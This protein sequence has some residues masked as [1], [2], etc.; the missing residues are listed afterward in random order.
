MPDPPEQ[1]AATSQ[2]VKSV[3]RRRRPELS[4]AQREVE[5]LFAQPYIDPLTQYLADTRGDTGKTD[6]RQ[7]VRTERDHRCAVIAAR[8]DA[9]PPTEQSLAAYRTGYE[10]SCPED[11]AAYAQRLTAL[12]DQP[13]PEPAIGNTASP[14]L[15]KQLNDCY[16]LTAI[17]NFSEAMKACRQP[18]VQGDIKAQTNMALMTYALK[19]YASAYHWAVAAAPHSV[20]AAR[21]LGQMY[22]AGQGVEPDAEAAEK[23]NARARDQVYDGTR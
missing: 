5:T 7:R 14:E 13:E 11:V 6:L 2:S 19:D 8:Y 21:L 3:E 22:T 4:T 1:A 23:W 9:E 12:R 18:A 20:E 15:S 16:L 10:Y 17:R